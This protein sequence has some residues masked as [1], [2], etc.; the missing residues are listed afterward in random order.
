LT[1]TAPDTPGEY[2]LRY[3]TG[4]DYLTLARQPVT[5][6]AIQGSLT[7]PATVVAGDPFKVTWKGPD[8]PRNFITIVAKGAKEGSSGAYAYTV[9]VNPVTIIAPLAA[10]DYELRYSTAEKY[11]TLARAA[12]KVTPAKS[13]PGK[14]A[15]TLAK[16][17]G[18]GAVEI[19]L[20]ASG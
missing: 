15:V 7:G 18:G 5:V 10:G 2:E 6:T 12:I 8:N 20:D 4:Q 14:V 1:L 17:S 19:I 3:S 16:G 13:E 9:K 11:L